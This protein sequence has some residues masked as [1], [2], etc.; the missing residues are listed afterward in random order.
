M[1]A[2]VGAGVREETIPCVHVNPRMY[3]IRLGKRV[4]LD[5]AADWY[6]ETRDQRVVHVWLMASQQIRRHGRVIR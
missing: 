5:C 6:E 3:I 1:T 2:L 4:C